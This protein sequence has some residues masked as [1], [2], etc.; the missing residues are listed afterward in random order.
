[1]LMVEVDLEVHRPEDVEHCVSLMVMYAVVKVHTHQD[2]VVVTRDMLEMTVNIDVTQL[3]LVQVMAI[4][5]YGEHVF[6][7]ELMLVTAVTANVMITQLVLDMGS[8]LLLERVSVMLVSMEMT[9]HCHVMVKV[10]VLE[11]NVNVM[12]AI[13]EN[14]VNQNVMNM[15]RVI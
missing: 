6:V 2:P 7:T 14:F 11:D 1:M 10:S 3:L 8:V 9:A 4:A 15:V 5:R 12:V 13:W